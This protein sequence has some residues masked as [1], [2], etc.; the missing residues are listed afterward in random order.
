[1]RRIW[2]SSILSYNQYGHQ[3]IPKEVSCTCPECGKVSC[4]T[5]RPDCHANR[6]GL[7]SKGN[8]S[9][10]K[11]PTSF[12]IIHTYNGEQLAD[13][14]KLYINDQYTPFIQLENS[15]SIPKDL[16]RVYQSAINVNT[17]KDPSATA[18]LAKR[19]LESVLKSF[20]GE[21]VKGQPLSAQVESLPKYID[22]MKP[23]LSLNE[24]IRPDS[25]FQQ[26]LEL[27]RELDEDMATLMIELLEGLIEYLYILPTKIEMTHEKIQ[28]KNI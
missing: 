25:H 28:R 5:L 18:V 10:C 2:P 13:H 23:I 4:F 26:A 7:F 21:K 22:L 24:L 6:I 27:E 8:C 12:I 15:K 9:L 17:L 3:K 11:A 20:L 14:V 19:V 16:I 1:M